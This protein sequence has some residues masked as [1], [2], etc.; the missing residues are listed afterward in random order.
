MSTSLINT[1]FALSLKETKQILFYVV[2]IFYIII[3]YP[4][5]LLIT[6]VV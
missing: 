6:Y 1:R 2:V 5:I 3:Y 4:N